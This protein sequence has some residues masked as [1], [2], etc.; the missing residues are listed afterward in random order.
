MKKTSLSDKFDFY[1]DDIFAIVR[2]VLFGLA[3][4]CIVVFG[5]PLINAWLNR[6]LTQ[7]TYG[8]ITKIEEKKIDPKKNYYD[9]KSNT[10]GYFV[11]FYYFAKHQKIK[12][13]TYLRRGALTLFQN[14]T[15]RNAKIGDTLTVKYNPQNREEAKLIA[16]KFIR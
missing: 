11:E 6:N 1:K 14:G 10:E 7:E 15:I 13:K 2:A 3:L 8:V 5:K 9:G 16:E 4:V 12:Q